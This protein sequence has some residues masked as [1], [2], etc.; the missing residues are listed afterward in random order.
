MWSWHIV[1]DYLIS[2]CVTKKSLIFLMTRLPFLRNQTTREQDTQTCFFA[3][4]TLTL[5]RW[6][7]YTKL[8]MFWRRTC[9]PKKMKFPGPSRLS[10]VIALQSD[11][12]TNRE[13]DTQ[14][15]R[16]TDRCEW[17]HYHA[18]LADGNYCLFARRFIQ[19]C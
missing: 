15:D 9:I 12:Q 1:N 3:P 2:A 10:E 5:T 19:L 7:W 6:P 16:Q 18:A 13:T 4:V 17:N 14:T 8:K 11:R